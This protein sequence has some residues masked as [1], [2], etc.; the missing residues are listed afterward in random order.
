M[1][2][3]VTPLEL[4][5]ALEAGEPFQV[6]DVRSPELVAAS[7]IE[8]SQGFFNIP[9][10]VLDSNADPAALGLDR[11]RPLA[12]VCSLGNASRPATRVLK[13]FGFA[14]RSI[15]GGMAAWNVAH[16]RIDLEPPPGFHTLVVFERFALGRRTVL[17]GSGDAAV[18]VDPGRNL[19]PFLEAAR[20]LGLTI[21]AVVDTHL[22]S[23]V[24]SGGAGLAKHQGCRYYLPTADSE[25]SALDSLPLESGLA[26]ASTG[27]S[28]EIL[29]TP[30][31]TAGSTTLVA[32][33][34][35][36]TGDFLL[37]DG[38]G[39]IETGSGPALAESLHATAT[40]PGEGRI[41]PSY[42][43]ER[44]LEAGLEGLR[45]EIERWAEFAAQSAR[46]PL[47]E[48][49]QALVRANLGL[50]SPDHATVRRREIAAREIRLLAQ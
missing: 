48:N 33:D 44:R 3:E 31:H 46:T 11:S 5:L 2:P 34:V 50:E 9:S 14:A 29:P 4:L 49:E 35:Y 18:V 41:V 20:E 15:R 25:G 42:G 40:W 10:S 12:V 36:L 26:V 13:S 38:V 1:T 8:G 45:A 37:C 22:H 47:D 32:G 21:R 24:L 39:R 27:V 17:L 43:S 16:R 23:D 6:I 28:I 30:G 7:R 19:A